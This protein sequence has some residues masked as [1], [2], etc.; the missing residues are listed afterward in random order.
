MMPQKRNPD[1]AEL[2]RAQAGRILGDMVGLAVVLKGLPLS[3]DRDLQEDKALV[4]DAHDALVAALEA[5]TTMVRGLRFD[6]DRLAASASDADLLATDLAERLVIAGIPFREAHR[7]VASL[8]RNLDASGAG[9]GDASAQD[10]AALGDGI[11][12][13]YLSAGASLDARDGGGPSPSS[14]RAQLRTLG[15]LLERK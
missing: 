5:M 15:T 13:E 9:L 7:R 11:T 12:P 1:V 10:L 3:Y 14:V 2:A 6:A 4:F 8:V